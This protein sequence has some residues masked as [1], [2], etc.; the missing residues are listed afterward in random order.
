M[1]LNLKNPRTLHAIDE[2]ARLT[3]ESKS[4]AVAS[5]IEARLAALLAADEAAHAAD[6]GSPRDR[7]RAL[8][9]DAAPRFARAGLGADSEG[10]HIDPTAELYDDAGLPR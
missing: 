8:M 9:A 10:R 4:E 3:G 2:L 5:A 6:R 1:A 7:L